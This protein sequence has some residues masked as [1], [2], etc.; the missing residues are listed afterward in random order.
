MTNQEG[1]ELFIGHHGDP[2]RE[3]TFLAINL[4]LKGLLRKPVNEVLHG[5]NLKTV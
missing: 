2:Q 4:I 5:D 1:P 3:P